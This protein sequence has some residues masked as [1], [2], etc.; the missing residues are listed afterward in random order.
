METPVMLLVNF[1]LWAFS[2]SAAGLL[3]LVWQDFRAPRPLRRNRPRPA[4]RPAGKRRKIAGP[5]AAAA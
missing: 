4:G 2:L 5:R 1:V 3:A